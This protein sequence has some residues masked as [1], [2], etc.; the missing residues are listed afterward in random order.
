MLKH[1]SPIFSLQEGDHVDRGAGRIQD[2][3]RQVPRGHG[4]S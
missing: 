2:L 3:G 1:V 4:Q